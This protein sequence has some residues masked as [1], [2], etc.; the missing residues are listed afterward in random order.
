MLAREVAQFTA[1]LKRGTE[2]HVPH[3]SCLS[4]PAHVIERS[5]HEDP[6]LPTVPSSH[7]DLDRRVLVLWNLR[8]CH[9]ADR[10]FRRG[11]PIGR[12]F[13][14]IFN[15]EPPKPIDLRNPMDKRRWHPLQGEESVLISLSVSVGF[16]VLSFLAWC[17]GKTFQVLITT[18]TRVT[19]IEM[20]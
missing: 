7:A 18:I 17:I 8:L 16:V 19:F 6:R 1:H 13:C 4:R 12:S 20:P 14:P 10:S 9:Y 3:W 2:A 15:R 11:S 5:L